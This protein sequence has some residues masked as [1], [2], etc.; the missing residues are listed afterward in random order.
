MKKSYK[1]FLPFLVVVFL[2]SAFCCAVFAEATFKILV[3][4]KGKV[5]TK[6][7]ADSDWKQIFS[8]RQVGDDDEARTLEASEGKILLPGG[9]IVR[10]YD[11]TSVQIGKI[12]TGDTSISSQVKQNAGKILVEVKRTAGEKQKF[13]VQTPTAVLAVRGP[14]F[15]SDVAGDGTTSAKAIID[16]LEVT[17]QGKTVIC[18]PG[19][20]T[21]IKPGMPP[22]NPF[23]N[24]NFVPP[25]GIPAEYTPESNIAA[26]R[27]V[28]PPSGQGP[29]E[30]PIYNPG[31]QP[32]SGSG[33]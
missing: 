25:G 27:G 6:K 18:E 3:R 1:K 2:L 31:G 17:A 26:P 11:N 22:V 20:M 8:Q 33:P 30:P 7:A 14:V 32:G 4:V 16:P 28:T 10:M 13:E 15:Y 24:P 19:F 29:S 21:V 23:A 9:N 12:E 5:E